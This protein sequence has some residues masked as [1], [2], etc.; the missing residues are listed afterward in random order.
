MLRIDLTNLIDHGLGA[1]TR[2]LE[3]L[4]RRD[5]RL[6]Q[7]RPHPHLKRACQR[8]ATA[9]INS[10]LRVLDSALSTGSGARAQYTTLAT[11]TSP[12]NWATA[13]ALKSWERH[14]ARRRLHP[15]T[16]Q[17]TPEALKRPR[18][19]QHALEHA[20]HQQLTRKSVETRVQSVGWIIIGSASFRR[21]TALA[22]RWL[23]TSRNPTS[24][25]C[26]GGLRTDTDTLFSDTLHLCCQR[27]RYLPSQRSA[28]LYAQAMWTMN[29]ALTRRSISL[30]ACNAFVS[31]TGAALFS[32]SQN[33]APPLPTTSETQLTT[34]DDI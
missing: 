4:T 9:P 20:R 17:K 10:S 30:R 18:H 15:S 27:L 13:A 16:F 5:L 3:R 33:T 19:K 28:C 11:S 14:P 31:G 32:G 34:S 23:P 24:Y 6:L 29:N 25:L 1:R 2:L 7:P 12:R 26:N 22:L 8:G 21:A